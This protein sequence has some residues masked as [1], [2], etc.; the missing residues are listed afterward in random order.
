MRLGKL[1]VDG[2]EYS[3]NEEFQQEALRLADDLNLDERQAAQLFLQSQNETD[4]TGRPARTISI[5][6]FHQRRKCVLDCLR[7]I[8]QQIA[9]EGQNE[10]L[11]EFLRAFV[12]QVVSPQG[13]T[14]ARFV[15]KC[16]STMAD[17]KSW[18]Q[19]LADKFNSASVLGQ[20][21]VPEF[22]EIIEFQRASLVMQHE[23]LGVIV[24]YLVKQGYSILS[25]LEHVLNTLKGVDKYDS[26]LREQSPFSTYLAFHTAIPEAQMLL[27]L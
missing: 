4:T 3:V 23:T 25:D 17:V 8:L 27:V 6:R 13:T 16:L 24:H 26:L 7:I 19:G 2:V 20:V 14:G 9:D 5:I 11:R 10:E 1:E 18:L 15:Q 21:Q 22:V 12:T